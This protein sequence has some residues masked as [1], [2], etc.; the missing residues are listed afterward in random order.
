M[1]SVC[2]AQHNG[3]QTIISHRSSE[4]E[5]TSIADIPVILNAGQIK[6]GAPARTDCACKYNRLLQIEKMLG[7]ATVY[8]SCRPQTSNCKF[9]KKSRRFLNR[10]C[11][12]FF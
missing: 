2:L 10:N 9:V 11:R 1:Q 12:D 7:D 6:T 4:T 8:P 5:D 3:Y